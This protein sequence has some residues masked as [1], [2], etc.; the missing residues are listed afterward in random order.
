M[1]R[2]AIQLASGSF[3]LAA[4]IGQD[5]HP[6]IPLPVEANTEWQAGLRDALRDAASRT[7]WIDVSELAYARATRVV[8]PPEMIQLHRSARLAA[9]SFRYSPEI[10]VPLLDDPEPKVRVWAAFVLLRSLRAELLPEVARLCADTG[11]FASAGGI[12]ASWTPLGEAPKPPETRPMAVGDAVRSFL[13]LWEG[14]E[15]GTDAFDAWCAE[16][17]EHQ[18]TARQLQLEFLLRTGGQLNPRYWNPNDVFEVWQACGAARRGAAEI[19]RIALLHEHTGLMVGA[20]PSIGSELEFDARRLGRDNLLRLLAGKAPVIDGEPLDP[21]HFEPL[22]GAFQ[23]YVLSRP[24]RLGLRPE[25]ARRLLEIGRESKRLD[26][27]HGAARLRPQRATSILREAIDRVEHPW[28]QAGVARTACL[29]WDLQAEQNVDHLESWFHNDPAGPLRMMPGH[30][31]DFLLHLLDGYQPRDRRMFARLVH[32]SRFDRCRPDEL[33]AI[34]RGLN[35]IAF[36]PAVDPELFLNFMHPW[37]LDRAFADLDAARAA[38]P[39]PTEE[40]LRR[41]EAMRSGIRTAT[42]DWSVD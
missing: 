27:F 37:G 21:I 16:L 6:A 2:A 19:A 24:A 7:P 8:A 29:L 34:A 42:E 23:A 28:L 35:R 15:P 30:R 11:E 4:A 12:S 10:A 1:P 13:A 25:D 20:F 33:L 32:D 17:R 31:Q 36:Q 3:C 22:L 39:G 5:T 40:M 41:M 9:D 26:L 38:M 14:P 18:P